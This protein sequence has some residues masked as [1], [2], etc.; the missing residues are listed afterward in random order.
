MKGC[1]KFLVFWWAA[2]ALVPSLEGPAAEAVDLE[3][4][5]EIADNREG[6]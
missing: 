6:K 1:A 3:L 2:L 4:V 5:L